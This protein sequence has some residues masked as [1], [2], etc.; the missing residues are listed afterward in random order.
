MW[1]NA[2]GMNMLDGGA[3]FYQVYECRDRRFMAV[4]SIE[5]KFYRNLLVGLAYNDD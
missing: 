2:R 1:N 3:H 4:G 5:S